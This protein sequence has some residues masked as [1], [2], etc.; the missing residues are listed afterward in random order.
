[1]RG[2]ALGRQRNPKGGGRDPW[3]G[4]VGQR[5]RGALITML[6]ISMVAALAACS[7]LPGDTLDPM[8]MKYGTKPGSP[9]AQTAASEMKGSPPVESKIQSKTT[10]TNV[11]VGRYRDSRGNGE[12]IFSLVRREAVLSGIW[13]LR[14]GGGG[15][16]N[17]ITAAGAGRMTF[18]MENTAPECP[19]T[20]EGWAEIGEATMIGAYHGKD[21]EGVVSD[22][23]LDLRPR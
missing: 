12:I 22:G 5:K 16:F 23:R 17:A 21:C 15:P 2:A 7:P 20:F 11:W 18:R 1:M 13:K 14:T 4:I 9:P 3:G 10:G 8:Y 19:G 6:A